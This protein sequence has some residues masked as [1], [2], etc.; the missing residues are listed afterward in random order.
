[1]KKKYVMIR[2]KVKTTKKKLFKRLKEIQIKSA[3]KAIIKVVMTLV[4]I[5]KLIILIMWEIN[6]MKN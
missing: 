3:F 1:M 4:I 2:D 5:I 6:S